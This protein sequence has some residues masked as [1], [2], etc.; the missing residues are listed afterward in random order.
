MQ[1]AIFA[2]NIYADFKAT[3]LK[4]LSNVKGVTVPG[5]ID[6]S[7]SMVTVS[8]D[9]CHTVIRPSIPGSTVN[10]FILYSSLFLLYS[11]LFVV[12]IHKPMVI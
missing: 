11:A 2:K 3:L 1:N 6:L 9:L 12:L 5:C 4:L 7:V 10:H 8:L